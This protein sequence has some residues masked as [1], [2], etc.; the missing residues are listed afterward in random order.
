MTF[1]PDIVAMGRGLGD[2]PPMALALGGTGRRQAI[3]ACVQFD[4]GRAK[5]P[6]DVEMARIGFDE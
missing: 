1:E 2:T 6:R 4:H 3:G 5:R